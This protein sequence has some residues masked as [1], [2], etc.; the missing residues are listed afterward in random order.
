MNLTAMAVC[1][2]HGLWQSDNV[3]VKVID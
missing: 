3:E 2:N 1:T